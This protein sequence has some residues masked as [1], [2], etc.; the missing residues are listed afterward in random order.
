MGTRSTFVTVLAWIFIVLSG[1]GTLISLLQNIMIHLMFPASQME[2]AMAGQPADAPAFAMF[3]A[4]NIRLFFA[5]FLLVSAATLFASVGLLRR[6]N[7]ARWAFVGLMAVGIAWN[8]AGFGFQ[9]F[10]FSSMVPPDV[11]GPQAEQ[12]RTMITAML[13]VGGVMAAGMSVLFGWIIKRLLSRP[14]AD[15]FRVGA[16]PGR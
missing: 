16:L 9:L 4:A 12:V 8:I 15:E 1:F 6:W 2:Q 11:P 3:M 5:F 10:M 7:W 14:I 13:V